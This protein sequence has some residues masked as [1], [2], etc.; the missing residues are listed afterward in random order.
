[1]KTQLLFI[2]AFM[3]GLSFTT[4]AQHSAVRYHTGPHQP[5]QQQIAHRHA[6][7]HYEYGRVTQVTP[8]YRTIA[9]YHPQRVCTVHPVSHRSHSA[10]PVVMG[11]IIGGALGHAVGN[12]NSNKKVGMAAGA[13]LGGSI[14][15]DMR[16]S[17]QGYYEDCRIVN[18]SVQYRQVLDGYQVSYRYRGQTYH[19]FTE[20]HPGNRIALKVTTAVVRR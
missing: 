17:T 4:N 11:A 8:V 6:A 3:T 5:Y 10:T 15:N 1:M 20:Q 13:I 2:S 9:E 16:H 18:S 14:A 12:N 7:Q 19:T